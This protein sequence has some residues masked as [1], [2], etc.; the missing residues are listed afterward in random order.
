MLMIAP[1]PLLLEMRQRS[2][3]IE[4]RTV[5]DGSEHAMPVGQRHGFQRLFRPA[6]R[7]VDQDVDTAETLD[8]CS[9]HA[10][11]R[12]FI[13]N[14]RDRWQRL[15]TSG[16]DLTDYRV[17]IGAVGTAV[18]YHRRTACRKLERDGAADVAT[19]ASDNRNAASQL[20]T[21]F[22]HMSPTQRTEVQFS[23]IQ[24]ARCRERGIDP[25]TP[26]SAVTAAQ[27]KLLFD[28]GARERLLRAAAHMRLA[29]L[30]HSAVVETH[31]DVAGER[32]RIRIV[33]IDNVRTLP[34][35]AST[36]GS[37]TAA[38]V[39]ASRPI[40]PCTNAVAMQ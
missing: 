20:F 23:I 3:H 5:Q 21:L 27:S 31:T 2:F 38:S 11:D 9:C 28:I 12:G 4:K 40:L 8:G 10:F 24:P 15:A 25:V 14:V 34:A 18:D 16:L 32:A 33:G 35:S 29:F 30:Q 36:V 13:C 17:D 22:G 37:F 26:P 1:A 39:N 7:V 6:R 19:S